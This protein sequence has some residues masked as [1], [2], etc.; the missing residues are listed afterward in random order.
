VADDYTIHS[1][2]S[3]F[4]PAVMMRDGSTHAVIPDPDAPDKWIVRVPAR[5]TQ[6]MER[7][8]YPLKASRTRPRK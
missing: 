7:R 8:G 4:P 2:D 5:Y 3:N 1:A 6:D